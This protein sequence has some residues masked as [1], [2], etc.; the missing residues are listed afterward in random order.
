MIS[1]HIHFWDSTI[2]SVHA[3]HPNDGGGVSVALREGEEGL[4]IGFL[5]L[6]EP[7]AARLI[8]V[9]HEGFPEL[10]PASDRDEMLK[11]LGF[12]FDELS[13]AKER[14]GATLYSPAS[15][16]IADIFGRLDAADKIKAGF[17]EPEPE[18]TR[19]EILRE[20]PKALIEAE[21]GVS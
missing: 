2:I 1:T 4:S 5:T 6:R 13:A 18:P 11:A 19:D 10:K 14:S 15:C 21:G 9:L 20:Y 8:A 16:Y 7:E 3:R 12:A 17:H